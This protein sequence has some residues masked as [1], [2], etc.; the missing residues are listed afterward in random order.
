[1]TVFLKN[2]SR[3]KAVI[4]DLDGTLLHSDG[5]ISEYTLEMIQEC[6]RR[7]IFVVVATAR[8]WLKAEKYLDIIS[9]DYAI[10]ADGTQIYHNGE[11]IHGYPMDEVQRD[12]IIGNLLQENRENGFVV[13]TGKKLLC[14]TAG[15]AE[16]WRSSRDFTEP[17]KDSVYKIAAI[18]KS[19]EEAKELAEKFGCRF[20]SYRG[21]Q[22]YGFASEKSGKFQAV[23]KLGEMLKIGMEEMLAFGDDENDREILKNVGKGVAVANAVPMIKEIADDVTQSND[24]DGVARYIEKELIPFWEKAYREKDVASFSSKPNAAIKEFE[25]LFCSGSRVLDVGCGEGQNA[26]YLAEQGHHVDAFD[27]S[28]YGIAKVNDRCEASGVKL[29]AFVADLTEF[30]FAQNYDLIISFGTLHFVHKSDWK[31][32]IREA[33]EHTNDGGIHIIQLFTDAVPASE[34]I[35]PFAVGLA[36]EEEIKEL[37]ADWEVLQFKS[38][39]FEDE[40]YGVPKHLH[41]SNKIV[42]RKR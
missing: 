39:V 15:I 33:K 27:L 8:F 30:E 37:Y 18:I 16:K 20:Y 31:K 24:E 13:S 42:A 28:E 34:D 22:L 7:G 25:K 1:M 38:Y 14:S 3:W 17:V 6:K 4:L 35:A 9:P 32:F 19:Y 10:L 29:N 23:A 12:G 26:I 21:E 41:A 11:M 2:Q 40:H 36:K 5:S